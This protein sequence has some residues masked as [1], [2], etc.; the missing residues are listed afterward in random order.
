MPHPQYKVF[1]DG[2]YI[3]STKYALEAAVL[4]GLR[5]DSDVRYGGHARK[6]IIWK[7]GEEGFSACESWDK[8]ASIMVS[9]VRTFVQ[10]QAR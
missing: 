7:E 5:M 6:N 8:A 1:V 4:A 2:E 9:R 3:A 10:A